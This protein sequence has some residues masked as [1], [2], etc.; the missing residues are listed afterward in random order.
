MV[1]QIVGSFP[2]WKL[3]CLSLSPL[4]HSITVAVFIPLVI[5]SVRWVCDA[6]AL[7]A[8]H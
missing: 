7:L 6:L 5:I 1:F 8:K 4:K 3:E 2:M